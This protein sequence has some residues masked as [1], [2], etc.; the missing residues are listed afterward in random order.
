MNTRLLWRPKYQ[1]AAAQCASCPFRVD[2]DHQFSAFA[3]RLGNV[4]GKKLSKKTVREARERIHREV[5]ARG[6]FV[7]HNTAYFS[8]ATLKDPKEHRQC[9]G[10]TNHYRTTHGKP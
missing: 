3:Q 8:N 1:E 2:N 5:E 6:D 10:A 9:P 4:I 7:C